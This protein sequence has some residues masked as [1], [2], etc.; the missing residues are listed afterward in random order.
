MRT[1]F[2]GVNIKSEDSKY[3]NDTS[4]CNNLRGREKTLKKASKRFL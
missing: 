3:T 1:S 2:D 4:F